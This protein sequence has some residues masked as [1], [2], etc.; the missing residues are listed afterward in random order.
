MRQSKHPSSETRIPV[1]LSWSL[2][3]GI[4]WLLAMLLSTYPS[5]WLPG[6]ST[7]HSWAGSRGE[8]ISLAPS[9]A[10]FTGYVA[11]DHGAVP[12]DTPLFHQVLQSFEPPMHDGNNVLVSLSPVEDEGY[13]PANVR[14]ATMSTHTRPSEWQDLSP[15][16]HRIKKEAFRLKFMSAL[17]HALPGAGAALVHAEFASPRSFQR[18]TRRL[19]G[20]VGG[21][22]VLRSNSN[23]FAVDPDVFGPGIWVVGDSVF[24]GQGTMATVMSAIR[25]V[26]R[27]TGVSWDQ[28]RRQARPPAVHERAATIGQKGGSMV[29]PD[30]G[31]VSRFESF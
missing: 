7:G 30:D 8:N 23:F 9:G 2:V 10:A 31:L 22:P 17:D 4:Y 29:E 20:A 24:P 21:A 25:V 13:G 5:T 19:V 11:I 27:I 15:A 28:L 14:V 1:V 16:M 6:C 26:E 18:Y 12:D 3:G